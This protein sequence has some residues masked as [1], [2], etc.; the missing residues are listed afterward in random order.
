MQK[1][2]IIYFILFG[3]LFADD[4]YDSQKIWLVVRNDKKANIFETKKNWLVDGNNLSSLSRGDAKWF[5]RNDSSLLTDDAILKIAGQTILGQQL[6]QERESSKRKSSIQLAI[7]LPLGS[8][9]LGGSAYW[10]STIW[11][12]E[13]PSTID[14]A[15]SLV[16]GVAGLGIVI[17]VISSYVSHHKPPDPKKHSISLKQA[18]DIIDKYNE[19]LRR[20]CHSESSELNPSGR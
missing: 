12:N 5:A 3:I 20:K 8:G 10:G 14:L 11:D 7:G 13:T 18:S 4:C 1:L 16:L 6:A 9:L 17:G 2:F 19:A 15:G